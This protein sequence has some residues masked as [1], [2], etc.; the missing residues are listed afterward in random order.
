MVKLYRIEVAT[1]LRTTTLAYA[2][3][4]KSSSA[5]AG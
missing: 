4:K 1:E 3:Y 5:G 2:S